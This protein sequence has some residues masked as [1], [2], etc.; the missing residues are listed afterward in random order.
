VE[1]VGS[2][3]RELGT[4]TEA[5]NSL[6]EQS[7]DHGAK[8]SEVSHAIHGAKVGLWIVGVIVAAA[9]SVCGFFLKLIFDAVLALAQHKP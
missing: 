6:K 9:G 1:L 8:I 4:L 7:R 3:Q 5:V 2:I